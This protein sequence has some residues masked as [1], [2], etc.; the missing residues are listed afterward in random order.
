MYFS[1]IPFLFLT[2]GLIC[3]SFSNFLK[4]KK[5]KQWMDHNVSFP[6]SLICAIKAVNL[7]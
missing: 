2:L 7:I 4:T 5:S 6:S 3:C 1:F